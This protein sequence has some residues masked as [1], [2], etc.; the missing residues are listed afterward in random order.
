[1]NHSSYSMI[2]GVPV[3]AIGIVGY[4]LIGL[5]ALFGKRNWTLIAAIAGLCFALYY[6]YI[7]ANVL[8]VWCLYCV[9][10]QGI[11][12]LISILMII[13][14]VTDVIRNISSKV[15]RAVEWIVTNIRYG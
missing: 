5:L 4:L 10:S 3:A 6:T 2:H 8:E 1:M 7:E 15:S 11:I 14:V 13:S 12:A 9:I